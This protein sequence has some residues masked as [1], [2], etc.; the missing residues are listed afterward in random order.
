MDQLSP[1]VSVLFILTTFVSVGLLL[2]G[3]KKAGVESLPTRLLVFV[4]PLWILFQGILATGGF[5][6]NAAPDRRF[7]FIFGAGPAALF[8]ILFSFVFRGAF[9]QKLPFSF[10]IGVHIV[11]IPVE[12]VLYLLYQGGAVPRAMTFAGYNFDIVTGIFAVILLVAYKRN[13]AIHPRVLWVFNIFGLL[14][15][16]IIV[17]IAI[18]ALPGA[19]NFLTVE[20]PN[21]AVLFFPYIWLPTIIVPIVFFAHLASL[22]QLIVKR[23][24][25]GR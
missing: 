25:V 12:I 17:S 3:A 18:L 1:A 21:V 16:G 13:R 9:I 2:Q 10:L 8:A 6:A 14:L 7:L 4:L 22:T 20:Q 19:P 24:N 15:L 11:R 23:E 5:Y